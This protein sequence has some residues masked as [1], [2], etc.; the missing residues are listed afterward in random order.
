MRA[1]LPQPAEDVDVHAFYAADWI[2]DGGLRVNFVSSADGAAQA[3]GRSEGLQTK[4]DNR[5]FAALRDLAD[6]IVA[7]A[8]TVTI[9]GYRAVRV[10]PR[11]A[12][13]RQAH[14]LRE[15]LPTAVI[16]RSL[17]LD[18]DS[19]LF[20]DARPDARTIVLTCEAA[21]AD[22]RAALQKVA[23]V[24][25]CGDEQV[26]AGLAKA[27]LVE[28]GL[29]R[30]LSEGGPITFGYLIEGGVVDELCLSLTPLL[31]GPGP[32]RITAGRADWPNPVGMRLAGLLEEDDALFLRYRMPGTMSFSSKL[33]G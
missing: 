27:A 15:V 3:D 29:T 7:G 25:M 14:G 32:T 9:E 28:R 22:R 8:G 26:D 11:R 5:I 13:I 17:R 31:V 12:A 19:A 30:I 16:S 4:G 33:T 20:V 21:P 6:V 24:A 1:L 23:D 2:E 18:P 10:S